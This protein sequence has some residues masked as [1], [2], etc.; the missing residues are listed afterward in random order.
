MKLSRKP[1]DQEI[2][3]HI[4]IT[5]LDMVVGTLSRYK[6]LKI[7]KQTILN[8]NVL[9]ILKGYP[10]GIKSGNLRNQKCLI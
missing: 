6:S 5:I 7:W 1:S 3:E 10:Q 9:R 4:P 8:F 2:I